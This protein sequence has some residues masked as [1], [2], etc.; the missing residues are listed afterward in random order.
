[1][2]LAR[3]AGDDIFRFK[4]DFIEFIS[5]QA[6]RSLRAAMALVVA[7]AP[8]SGIFAFKL[9]L[10]ST[11]AKNALTSFDQLT[12]QLAIAG[13]T[14][15]IGQFEFFSGSFGFCLEAFVFGLGQIDHFFVIAKI[16]LK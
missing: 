3:Y 5:V 6:A 15:F 16:I 14:V 11:K 7:R 1:L 2:T 4:I 12:L 13:E 8:P 9:P 10:K